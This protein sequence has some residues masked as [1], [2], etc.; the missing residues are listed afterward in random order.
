MAETAPGVTPVYE[1]PAPGRPEPGDDVPLAAVLVMA[2]LGAAAI[3]QG[4]YHRGGQV[5]TGVLLGAAVLSAVRSERLPVGALRFP[6]FV[7]AAAL[8]GWAAVS[9]VAAGDIGGAGPT[10]L[11]LAGCVVASLLCRGA[12]DAAVVG[13][14]L[15][16]G[17]VALSG[18]GGLAWRVEP[19]ALEGQGVWQAAT[20][21]TYSNAA[22]GLLVPLVL[23]GASR[24]VSLPG[25][26]PTAAATCLL[27]VGAGATLSRGGALALVVGGTVLA[28]RVGMRPLAVAVRGP[29]A[30]AAVALCALVPSMVAARPPAPWLAV[31]GLVA[32]LL[33]A[34]WSA[35]PRRPRVP[36]VA[37]LAVLV[38]AALVLG[39]SGIGG[40]A[41]SAGRRTRLTLG[42]ADRVDEARAALRVGAAHPVTGAGP[43]RAV[44]SW[45][46]PDGTV[47]AAAYA[48]NEYLQ[49]FA[50]LGAVGLLLVLAL[51]VSI[52]RAARRSLARRPDPFKAGAAAGLAAL[53]VH[54]GLD[55]LWRVPAIPLVAAVLVG[56][57]CV[58]DEPAREVG[59]IAV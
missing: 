29:A 4:G 35:R 55:F 8:A 50:E 49:T 34:A 38:A 32:G 40:Q 16:G 25:S 22:A 53:A 26:A 9:A 48:H 57:C 2:A 5:L 15:L 56:L 7:L 44:L 11:L 39:V 20:T 41:L 1:E 43:G 23:L 28:R 30:G 46:E 18:V 14:L 52:G 13:L 12:G 24:L 54:S 59:A 36:A 47:L 27:L 21:L 42:S 45:R 19:W 58:P 31:A 17:L 10:V 51:L 6:P 33:V 3:A 37:V